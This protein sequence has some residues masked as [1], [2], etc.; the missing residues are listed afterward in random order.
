[1]SD[2]YLLSRIIHDGIMNNDVGANLMI[3][4]IK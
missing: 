2:C 1:M 3:T 4:L